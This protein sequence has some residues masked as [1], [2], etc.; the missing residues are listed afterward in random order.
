MIDLFKNALIGQ[1]EAALSMLNDCIR[2][3]PDD[4]WEANVNNFPFWHV[5][6]H[7]L[8]YTDMYLSP[9]LESYKP[10]D[11]YRENYQFFGRLPNPPHEPIVV[12][13]VYDK[14]TILA[15]V[16]HCRE[17]IAGAIQ[18]ETPESLAGPSGFW[19]YHI[20]RSEFHLNNIRHVQHHAAQMIQFLRQSADIGIGWV[21]SGHER[22]AS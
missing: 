6:Y 14:E 22:P 3:C 1:Y 5:A 7:T 20:P 15:Y 8:F 13:I 19:W 11:H 18:A 10:P 17:K 12:D 4:K 2:Q 21:Q 16:D 9:D